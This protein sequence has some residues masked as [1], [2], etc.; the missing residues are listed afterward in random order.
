MID[1]RRAKQKGFITLKEAAQVSNYSPD[2]IGQLI[3]SGKIE[4]EQV[5]MNVAWVTTKK[6][7]MS[8]V[9]RSKKPQVST[10][11]PET[12]H[13]KRNMLVTAV[14]IVFLFVILPALAYVF[15]IPDSTSQVHAFE[16]EKFLEE[17]AYN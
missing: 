16:A 13:R 1:A 12:N 11:K 4:G 8:Y 3:R 5:Y 10:T 9:N 17:H 15:V 14:A 7:I 2:Y 6:E